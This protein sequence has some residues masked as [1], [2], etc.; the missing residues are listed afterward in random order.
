MKIE[1][2]FGNLAIARSIHEKKTP[3]EQKPLGSETEPFNAKRLTYD[4]LCL[5]GYTFTLTDVK[6]SS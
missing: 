3:Q 4:P 1:R 2:L 5:S 6:I